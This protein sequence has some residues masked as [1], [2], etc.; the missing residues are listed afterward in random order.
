MIDCAD[1][2]LEGEW[3]RQ[4]AYICKIWELVRIVVRGKES[5]GNSLVALEQ[6]ASPFVHQLSHFA[7][8]NAENTAM[9]QQSLPRHVGAS[10][11][12]R[13][14]YSISLHEKLDALFHAVAHQQTGKDQV[15][16]SLLVYEGE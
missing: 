1:K 11:E 14:R 10:K 5:L 15:R 4:G 13:L 16:L 6:R 12:D 2:T 9:M 8:E 7:T 3:P